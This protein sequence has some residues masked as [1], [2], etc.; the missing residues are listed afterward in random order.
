MRAPEEYAY[1]EETEKID[2]YSFGNILYTILTNLDPWEE[3]SEEVAVQAVMKGERPEVPSEFV[4]SE[5]PADAAIRK[6]MY[7][8]WEGRPEERPRARALADFLSK[9]LNALNADKKAG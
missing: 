7:Q 5:D 8:C 3:T 2:V 6:A 4:S 9:E 1:A